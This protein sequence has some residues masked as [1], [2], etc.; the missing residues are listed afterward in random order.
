MDRYISLLVVLRDNSDEMIGRSI[1]PAAKIVADKMHEAIEDLPVNDSGW[2]TGT[3]DHKI[4]AITKAQKDG[5][6]EGLGIATL[7]KHGDMLDVKIGM[8]GYNRTITSKYPYGQPNALIAR[9]I[10]SGTS[11]R[12]KN[13]FINRAVKASKAEAEQAMQR[14]YDDQLKK[15]GF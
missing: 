14:E 10:E 5:L 3:K 12:K 1:Y 6:L 9:S 4:G 7:Q 13:P 11:F 8:D 2:Y 15:I